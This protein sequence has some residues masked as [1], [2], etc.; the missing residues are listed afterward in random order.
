MKLRFATALLLT[1]LALSLRAA[2]FLPGDS[3]DALAGL[4]LHAVDALVNAPFS[5]AAFKKMAVVVAALVRAVKGAGDREGQA[6]IAPKPMWPGHPSGDLENAVV[7]L[8]NQL[9]VVGN[10]SALNH[11][12]L[13]QW[14]HGNFSTIQAGLEHA[15]HYVATK[16]ELKKGLWGLKKKLVKQ[17]AIELGAEAAARQAKDAALE[18][19]IA[20]NGSSNSTSPSP[21]V[22]PLTGAL[23]VATTSNETNSTNGTNSTPVPFPAPATAMA[24]LESEIAG[25]ITALSQLV[26]SNYA[27]LASAIQGFQI[28]QS[29]F[30]ATLN[31]HTTQI[32]YLNTRQ[33]DLTSYFSNQ[34]LSLQSSLLTNFTSLNQYLSNGVYGKD[35]TN[36]QPH[37]AVSRNVVSFSSGQADPNN[38]NQLLII[39]PHSVSFTNAPAVTVSLLATSGAAL[40]AYTLA[41]KN[42]NTASATVVVSLTGGSVAASDPYSVVVFGFGN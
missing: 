21:V 13:T 4:D 42:V 32:N 24:L 39:V 19:A 14:V 37:F 33:D 28:G 17:F 41:V 25:N 15:A 31:G 11:A 18:A 29:N 7:S 5:E 10:Q 3:A 16:K 9:N 23:W 26:Q 8:Q 40:P 27:S 36:P 12:Q 30:N 35:T 1:T 22:S 20:E 2:T 38:P 34:Y 6:H